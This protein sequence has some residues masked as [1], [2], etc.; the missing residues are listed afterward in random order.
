MYI[1]YV[2]EMNFF[3]SA[4]AQYIYMLLFALCV[5]LLVEQSLFYIRNSQ[6]FVAVYIAWYRS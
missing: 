1:Y 6:F 5:G 4:Y 2:Y 3:R